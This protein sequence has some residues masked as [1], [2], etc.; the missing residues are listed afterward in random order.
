MAARVACGDRVR[1]SRDPIDADLWRRV[2]E[3]EVFD[4]EW[5]PVT[6]SDGVVCEVSM[7]P[8]RALVGR[9]SEQMTRWAPTGDGRD[10]PDLPAFLVRR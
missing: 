2:L 6:S 9:G 4:R 1:F 7:L 5:R 8:K 10:M 3:T